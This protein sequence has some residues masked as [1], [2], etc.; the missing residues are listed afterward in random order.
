MRGQNWCF[1]CMESCV[2]SSSVAVEARDQDVDAGDRSL[3]ALRARSKCRRWQETTWRIDSE[4]RMETLAT[5]HLDNRL[6]SIGIGLRHIILWK[7]LWRVSVDCAS[8]IERYG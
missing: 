7:T 1:H 8:C 2:G 5:N 4:I 3:G 6:E